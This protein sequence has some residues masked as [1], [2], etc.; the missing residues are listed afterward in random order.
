MTPWKM[1]S[2]RRPRATCTPRRGAEHR[3]EQ[4][5]RDPLRRRVDVLAERQLGEQP[6]RAE[7]D[8]REQEPAR[9]AVG[10]L[11]GRGEGHGWDTRA[12]AI[13]CPGAF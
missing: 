1:R 4:R 13:G 7:R 12:R 6:C 3:D 10:V 2:A 9:R 5:E 11:G 8:E